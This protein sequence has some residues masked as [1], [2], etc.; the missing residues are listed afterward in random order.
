[1]YKYSFIIIILILSWPYQ[2]TAMDNIISNYVETIRLT[3]NG[4]THISVEI[5]ISSYQDSVIE[6]PL[7]FA[8]IQNLNT[9]LEYVDKSFKDVAIP[10]HY[11]KTSKNSFIRFNCGQNI[12]EK[13]IL[14]ME[15]LAPGFV[16]F[17]E[18]G[19][20]E[21]D[22]YNWN[23]RFTNLSQFKIENY[24]ARIVLPNGYNYHKVT[25]SIPK[26][27]KNNP[28]PPY[29]FETI[30]EENQIIISSDNLYFGDNVFIDFIFKS[31][32]KSYWIFVVGGI[33]IGLYLFF[34]RDI[35]KNAQKLIT[36]KEVNAT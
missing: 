30:E 31:N 22:A 13:L 17:D 9:S 23:Y 11:D 29:K 33:L 4:D 21:F 7:N 5:L 36:K 16:K 14:K 3:E 32:Q 25:G 26:F 35:W 24:N 1:M 27:T 8:L 19:P 18:L 2:S 28:T 10:V 15:F 12:R 20:S 34:F 6:I